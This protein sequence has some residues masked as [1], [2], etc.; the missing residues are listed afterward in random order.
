MPIVL[1]FIKKAHSGYS[2]AVFINGYIADN[3]LVRRVCMM[4]V[5]LVC[6]GR[7]LLHTTSPY[8]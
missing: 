5:F 7:S 1:F 6:G 4:F 2:N 8:G 3:E